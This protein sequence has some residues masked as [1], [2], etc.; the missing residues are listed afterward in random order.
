MEAKLIKIDRNG[1]KHYEGMIT[2]DRCGGHGYY[3]I[4]VHN[5]QP[6]LSPHDDGV[7]WKCGGSGK[8]LGKWIERTPEY[9]AKLD[10]RRK[11]KQEA[12]QAELDAKIDERRS[13][14]LTKNGF[15][16]DGFTYL[17]L[18]ETYSQ[19]DQIKEAGGKF[20][21][22]GWHIDHEVDG[23]Q[24][25]KVSKDEVLEA[26]YWG[27]EYKVLN[28]DQMRKEAF[29]KLNGVPEFEF[30]GTVGKRIELPVKYIRTAQW[31]VKGMWGTQTQY[32]HTFKDADGNVLV[33][34]TGTPAGFISGDEY[35]HLEEGQELI[36]IGTVKEHSEYKEQKQTV[37]TRCKCKVA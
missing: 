22:C 30:I 16:H 35:K 32:L 19:K 27:Y 12:K 9:Q 4:A 15:T 14:W 37:L 34:K 6:V 31:E 8:V 33:W 24:F 18:G 25:L 5:M 11:A 26:T 1:S 2:C 36:L 23:F 17:F 28:Y 3:A 21:D 13:E 7:C 10:S 20:A 29:I